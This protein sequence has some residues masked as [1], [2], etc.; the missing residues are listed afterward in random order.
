MKTGMKMIL[1]TLMLG[2]GFDARA[3]GLFHDSCIGQMKASAQIMGEPQVVLAYNELAYGILPAQNA[4]KKRFG[5]TCE[6]IK[7]LPHLGEIISIGLM[8]ATVALAAPGV[9][10][11]L[12]AELAALGLTLANPVVLGVTVIGATG[13]SVIYLVMKQTMEECEKADRQALRNEIIRELEMQFSV[14]GSNRTQFAIRK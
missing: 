13:V 2:S 3:G 6:Q 9:S 8:P 11:M 12:T 14:Q 4:P 1:L 5:L 10:G 7:S